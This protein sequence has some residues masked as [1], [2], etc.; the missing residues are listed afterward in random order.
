[1]WGRDDDG[2]FG[3]GGASV[4]VGKGCWWV[5]WRRW[6]KCKCGEGMLVGGLE[7]VGQV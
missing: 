3:G 2:W 7:E 1:M 6:G 4:S 5:V